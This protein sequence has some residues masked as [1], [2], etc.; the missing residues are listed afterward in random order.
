MS[1]L[2]DDRCGVCDLPLKGPVCCQGLHGHVQEGKEC[3]E[4]CA[5]CHT[6]KIEEW[7]PV[8]EP[9]PAPSGTG[10]EC[11]IKEEARKFNEK[12]GPAI[13]ELAKPDDGMEDYTIGEAVRDITK[14]GV[15]PAPKGAVKKIV[16]RLLASQQTRHEE[17]IAGLR[18]AMKKVPSSPD[19]DEDDKVCAFC[20]LMMLEAFDNAIAKGG[21]DV[22]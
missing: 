15:C 4:E 19:P 17:M 7:C 3:G 9:C 1:L 12:F 20:F 16:E 18:E 2:K 8:C 22:K 6:V 11:D 5:K 21:I 13:K 14:V 10:K